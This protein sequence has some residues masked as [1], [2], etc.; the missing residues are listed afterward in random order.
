MRKLIILAAV[1]FLCGCA[2]QTDF[3]ILPTSN[4]TATILEKEGRITVL[5]NKNSGKYHLDASCVYAA[6]MADENRLLIEVPDEAYLS[7][8]GYEPCS[9]CSDRNDKENN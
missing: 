7:E 3:Q 9:R 1:I 2:P 8:H 6:R 5:I 4:E